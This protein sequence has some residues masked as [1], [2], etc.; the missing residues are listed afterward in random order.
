MAGAEDELLDLYGTRISQSDS[1][2]WKMVCGLLPSQA[3]TES[4]C[5]SYH[6]TSNQT[7]NPKEQRS[8]PTSA[9][10][11]GFLVRYF[12]C[13]LLPKLFFCRVRH[14]F[15]FGLIR[16]PERFE[17]RRG[18][19]RRGKIQC[20]GRDYPAWRECSRIFLGVRA[21]SRGPL[22]QLCGRLLISLK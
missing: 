9:R 14:V 1:W 17:S 16:S 21:I 5:K 3:N 22:W 15:F 18:G 8:R 2:C 11:I 4:D 12:Q 10:L 6:Q 19:I 7:Y 13:R 20:Y